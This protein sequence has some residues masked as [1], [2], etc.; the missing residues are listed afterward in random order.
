[1]E[2]KA[3]IGAYAGGIAQIQGVWV[4]P[5]LRGQGIAAPCMASVARM[6]QAR[7]GATVHLYVNDF[8]LCAVRAYEKA[9]FIHVGDYAT[10]ML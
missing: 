1:M 4:L 2:F 5:E 9:G 3:D 8:N 6:V 10:I 7:L